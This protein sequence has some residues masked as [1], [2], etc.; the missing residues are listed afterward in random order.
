MTAL[1][2]IDLH[3]FGT[4]QIIACF[5]A[6]VEGGFVLFES[7]PASSSAAVDSGIAELGFSIEQLKGVF[8]TH[9]HLDHSGGAG[10]LSSRAGCAVYCH[11]EGAAH[12]ADPHAKLLPS[13]E[14]IYGEMMEPLWGTTVPVEPEHLVAVDHGEVVTAGGLEVVAWHTPGHAVHHV[15]WQIGDSIVT[16][17]VG[18]VRF[19][20]AT[21]VLPP[22]PPPDIQVED[23]R[24]SIDLLR[25]LQP[26]YLL[27]THYGSFDDPPRHLDELEDRLL[28]WTGIAAR[29]VEAGGSRDDL[30]LELE[31]LD[32]S[33][34]K[35]AGVASDAVERYRRLCPVKES[36]AGLFRYASQLAE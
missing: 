27:L 11:P 5:L 17:D 16:G 26:R 20:G 22:M 4:E 24:K 6:P 7:G 18:G 2:T 36:S 28:R 29:M 8:A 35:A 25:S 30:G 14:R 19:P 34:M 32:A 31:A 10:G 9:V 23:W 1:E 12:L 15:A 13:A 3:F 21:H 33:E